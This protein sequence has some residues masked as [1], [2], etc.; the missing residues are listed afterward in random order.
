MKTLRIVLVV[1]SVLAFTAGVA[2]AGPA[3]LKLKAGD[4]AYICGCGEKCA[5]Q[6]LSKK[7]G[8]CAC[9]HD[10]LKVTVSKVKGNKAYFEVGGKEQTASMKGKYT[11]PCEGDCCEM[12]SQKTGKCP[13]GKDLIQVT[14]KKQK[15][16]AS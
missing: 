11:C 1:T 15:K 4:T 13:C 9:D 2:L 6:V 5:C 16:T 12:I 7:P 3:E 10:L 8:K 14:E